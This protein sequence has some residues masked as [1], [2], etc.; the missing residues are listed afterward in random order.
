MNEPSN[1]TFI[2]SLSKLPCRFQNELT[3]EHSCIM[4]RLLK[5]SEDATDES[6]LSAYIAGE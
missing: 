6:W 4:L 1:V 3:G 5:E 2:F